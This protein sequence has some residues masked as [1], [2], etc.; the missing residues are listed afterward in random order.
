VYFSTVPER[1]FNPT[2]ALE[3]RLVE[4]KTSRDDER[5]QPP[6]WRR[7]RHGGSGL[8]PLSMQTQ[9]KLEKASAAVEKNPDADYRVLRQRSGLP[10]REFDLAVQWLEREGHV[11]RSGTDGQWRYRIVKPYRGDRGT[12]QGMHYRG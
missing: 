2:R 8:M 5:R 12:G 7:D 1:E 3:R 10:R 9:I 11:A 6:E 4:V